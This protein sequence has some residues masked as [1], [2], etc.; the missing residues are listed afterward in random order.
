MVSPKI[1]AISGL[2]HQKYILIYH[3]KP[4]FCRH[5]RLFKKK[6]LAEENQNL[7]PW[8]PKYKH[9]TVVDQLQRAVNTLE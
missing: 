5:L 9:V 8:P 4:F 6:K 2:I 1:S 7:D 3:L